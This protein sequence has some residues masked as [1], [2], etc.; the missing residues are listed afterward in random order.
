[1]YL[2]LFST[3][4]IKINRKKVKEYIRDDRTRRVISIRFP[5]RNWIPSIVDETMKLYYYDYTSKDGKYGN[6]DDM[7]LLPAF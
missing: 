4:N 2:F 3:K 7:N 1:M 6:D 5:F